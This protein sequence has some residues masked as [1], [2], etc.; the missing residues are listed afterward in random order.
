MF[1]PTP[2]LS[3]RSL[4]AAGLVA[5]LVALLAWAGLS[6]THEAGRVA[7]IWVA[8][9][10]LVGLLLRTPPE[11]WLAYLVAGLAGNLAADIAAGDSLATAACL[12]LCNT[13]EVVIAAYPLRA[14]VQR[15]LDPVRIGAAAHRIVPWMAIAP[16]APSAIGATIVA[17]SQDQSFWTAFRLWYAADFLGLVIMTPFVLALNRRVA[18]RLFTGASKGKDILALLLLAVTTF[19]V[20]VQ[21]QYPLLFLVLPP[22]L[23][24]VFRMGLAGAAL[25]L[26]VVS[27]IAVAC[28][29]E[30]HGP[31]S[32]VAGASLSERVL[33]LQFFV[34]ISSLMAYPVS[35]VLTERRRLQLT[36]AESE[37]RYRTLSENSSDII[38]RASLD[39]TRQYVSP[40]VTELLGWKPEELVGEMRRDLLHPDDRSGFDEEVKSIQAGLRS[41]T[42]AYR[43]QHKDGRYVWMEST[44][45]RS[46]GTGPRG[47]DEIVRVVRDISERKAILQALA[48]SER[49]LRA[50]TDN[51]P[52]LISFV[53]AGGVVQFCNGTHESWLG[54]APSEIVGRHLHEV[55]GEDA[56][57]RQHPYL[58]RALQ[59]ERVE[60]DLTL[61]LNERLRHT[62][63]SYVP[64]TSGEDAISG[65]YALITDMTALK[66]V[67]IQLV[68]LARFDS[69]TGLP[70][71]HQ[72]N[73]Q[74][75]QALLRARRNRAPLA[76][77]FLDVDR[78]KTINDTLGHGIGDEVLQELARRLQRNVRATDLAARLAGD[79]FVIILEGTRTAE[80][81]KR[82]ADKILAAMAAPFAMS[83][84]PLS[85]SVSIGV[86][87]VPEPTIAPA[88][89][90][91]LADTALY[92]AKAS[93]RNRCRVA[94]MP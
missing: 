20:F 94:C 91:H 37:R 77:L 85:V 3:R 26:L 39:G 19:G 58:S 34:A 63:V 12:A 88:E 55:L 89:V 81:P 27:A 86:A 47:E 16:A 93:G 29:I 40:S 56:Y 7:T 32:L 24:F 11:R 41:M 61:T 42:L 74:L 78:F 75:E 80:E 28:T 36:L 53:D 25:G 73:E 9:G 83:T 13:L 90:L 22:L 65:V 68:R 79:E 43:Y 2:A 31:F 87:F 33:L 69:L 44:A 5:A 70:N 35:V 52:V 48:K 92:E 60:F 21:D 14:L 71:R 30:G 10:F 62:R 4:L 45:R 38:V 64:R 82:V 51:L 8:N 72:L 54:R 57:A 15:D 50:V 59:G 17:L 49:D 23:L 1:A 84:G 18:M 6:L 76:V 66:A 46:E 67:E